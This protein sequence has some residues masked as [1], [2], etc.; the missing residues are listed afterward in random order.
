MR[1]KKPGGGPEQYT[2]RSRGTRTTRSSSRG[3]AWS[4]N[5]SIVCSGSKPQRRLAA[6]LRLCRVGGETK[7]LK[8]R[9]VRRR[10]GSYDS[11]P[12]VLFDAWVACGTAFLG[13]RSG[14]AICGSAENSRSSEST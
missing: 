8:R 6:R 13:P 11:L 3:V 10:V 4:A 14:S 12:A 9:W 7:K 2:K 1:Q 5:P